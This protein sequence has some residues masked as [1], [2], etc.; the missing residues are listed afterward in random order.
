M[1]FTH[2][3]GKDNRQTGKGQKWVIR[4]RVR[5][6]GKQ[7]KEKLLRSSSREM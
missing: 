2:S 3:Q 6:N 7:A 1:T 5:P 4:G